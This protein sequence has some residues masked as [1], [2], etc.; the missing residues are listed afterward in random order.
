MII[1]WCGRAFAPCW[2][3]R[4]ICKL[5]LKEMTPDQLSPVQGNREQISLAVYHLVDNAIKYS[6]VGAKIFVL[7]KQENGFA[8]IA[9]RDTGMGIWPKN[10]PFIFER[11]YR[12]SS[13]QVQAT[14]GQGL[15]LSLVKA[16]AEAHHG[17]VWTESRVGQGGLFYCPLRSRSLISR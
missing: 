4:E 15:G 12:V 5:T 8:T 16:I 13:P 2:E 9:V 3:R 14:P 7:G 6:P 17:R 1:I 11:F 10:V